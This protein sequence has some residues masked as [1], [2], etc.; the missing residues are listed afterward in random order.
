MAEILTD[1]WCVN[2]NANDHVRHCT[3]AHMRIGDVT[4]MSPK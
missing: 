3:L 2:V 1:H 4:Y